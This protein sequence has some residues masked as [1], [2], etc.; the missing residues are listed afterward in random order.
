VHFIDD[1][2]F[3]SSAQSLLRKLN[4]ACGLFPSELFIQGVTLASNDPVKSGGF[5]EIYKGSLGRTTVAIKRLRYC[6]SDTV[7]VLKKVSTII[8]LEDSNLIAKL[9]RCW[10]ERFSAGPT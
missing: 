1:V 5:G 7:N 8:L 4:D 3:R 2:D 10:L 9:N 6:T